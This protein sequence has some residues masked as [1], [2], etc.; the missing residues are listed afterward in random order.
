M[1][2]RLPGFLPNRAVPQI[3]F[4]KDSK[5]TFFFLQLRIGTQLSLRG[6]PCSAQGKLEI[7]DLER[8]HADPIFKVDAHDKFFNAIDR[9]GGRR[10]H[11][12]D[13]TTFLI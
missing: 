11:T 5:R 7:W 6:Q 8:M 12:A 13:A 10:G 9:I 4:Q 3:S 1:P 2:R